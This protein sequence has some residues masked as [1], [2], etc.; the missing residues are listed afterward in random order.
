MWNSF[1]GKLPQEEFCVGGVYDN[2]S[3]SNNPCGKRCNTTGV[4]L[5]FL[6]DKHILHNRSIITLAG[7]MCG[8]LLKI[9]KKGRQYRLG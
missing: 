5:E 6:V 4:K 9:K 8:K 2:T 1:L 7:D 3:F